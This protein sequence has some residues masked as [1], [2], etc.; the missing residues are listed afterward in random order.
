MEARALEGGFTDAPVASAMAFRAMLDAMARPGTVR[1]VDGAMPPAPLSV[2]AGTAAL[3]LCDPETPV[4]LGASVDTAP[5]RDWLAFHT[6]APLAPRGVAH[7]AFGSWAEMLPLKD[8]A[9]GTPAYPDRSATLV[10]EMAEFGAGHRLTGPGIAEEA[11]FTLPDPEA[12]RQNAALFPLG[13]DFI[14]TCGSRLAALPRTTGIEALSGKV[15]AGFPSES[16]TEQ[17]QL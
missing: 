14:F 13:L 15:D 2:A 4:W 1:D 7:F 10:V 16:A 8:F 6:G 5:V 11:W 12:L 17:E 3:T 9:L